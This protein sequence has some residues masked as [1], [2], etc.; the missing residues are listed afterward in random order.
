MESAKKIDLA[1]LMWSERY[2]P[3]KL[4]EVVN[5]KEIIKGDRKSTRLNSSH[6][7]ISYAVFCLKKTTRYQSPPAFFIPATG[8]TPLPLLSPL[9]LLTSPLLFTPLSA[10]APPPASA[11]RFIDPSPVSPS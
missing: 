4:R 1:N 11:T 7:I 8:Y 5:Q 2:R 9:I 10:L 6:A 3:K